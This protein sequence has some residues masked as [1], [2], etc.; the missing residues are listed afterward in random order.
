VS[1]NLPVRLAAAPVRS[2]HG[3]FLEALRARTRPVPGAA[4]RLDAL[5][6]VPGRRLPRHEPEPPVEPGPERAPVEIA[7]AESG[8]EASP[9][10]TAVDAPPEQAPAALQSMPA[11]AAE[12]GALPATPPVVSSRPAASLPVHRPAERPRVPLVRRL[13]GSLA[14]AARAIGLVR[15]AAIDRAIAPVRPAL[16]PVARAAPAV[17]RP[18][19]PGD[20][21][22]PHR[23]ERRVE[24]PPPLV[25]SPVE[26]RFGADLS[27]VRVHR[28]PGS[29]ATT[30]AI[31][32][33][34]F[35]A[36]GDV[37]VPA[38]LG[39]L[40]RGRAKALLTHE[41]VHVVQQRG[42]TPPPAEGSSRGRALEAQ[43]RELELA[44]A[45]PAPEFVAPPP[46]LFVKP[47]AAAAAAEPVPWRPPRDEIARPLEP[48]QAAVA[49]VPAISG[50]PL[51]AG[52]QRAP[53]AAAA[54]APTPAA[55][56]S[57]DEVVNR[58]Y[59]RISS[60]LRAE[61]LVDRERA[62]ALTDLR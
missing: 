11:V 32:A 56:P 27:G 34:A 17:E 43:A 2:R 23:A 41:L 61:L 6:V 13:A 59:D 5:V 44:A 21:H 19:T 57:L 48:Q 30:R 25:R 35:T 15:P 55:E 18:P 40:D 51:G 28:G 26:Q 8:D 4:G 42:L 47:P 22:P 45:R 20:T 58:L 53:E 52:I 9:A 37:H 31:R 1:R 46:E 10:T 38:E 62:G 29:T 14:P 12:A 49:G 24:Q 33:Q 54:G 16:G 36:H 60:R 39:P 50:P 3:A 7:S